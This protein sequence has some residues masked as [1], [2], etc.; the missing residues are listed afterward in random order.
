M[1]YVLGLP[2]TQLGV[3]PVIVVVDRFSK[4][5]RFIP[6]KKTADATNFATLFS[7]KL[8]FYMVFLNL[9]HLIGKRK[10]GASSGRL[11]MRLGT[12]LKFSW[13]I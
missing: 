4:M 10:I 7:R 2:R 12:S 3:N 1:D 6:C 5:A 9:S 11:W 8:C 13:A